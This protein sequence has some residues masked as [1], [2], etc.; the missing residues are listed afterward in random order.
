LTTYDRIELLKQTLASISSQTFSDYEVIIGNDYQKQVLTHEM[1]GTNDSRIHI[2]N[3]PV[4]LG[5]VGNMNAL[6]Q[7]S[8]GQ[9]YTWMGDDDIYTPDFLQKVFDVIRNYS[10]PTAVFTNFKQFRGLDYPELPKVTG[11]EARIYSG[12][13]F[14]HEYLDGKIKTLSAYGIIS[15]RALIEQGGMCNVCDDPSIGI[16]GEYLFMVRCGML[17]TISYLNAPLIYFR[18]HASSRAKMNIDIQLH[19]ATGIKLITE[20]LN[21]IKQAPF[22]RGFIHDLS[23]LLELPLYIWVY[24]LKERDS[25]RLNE[26]DVLNHLLAMKQQFESLKGSGLYFKAIYSLVRVAAKLY[27]HITGPHYTLVK[28]SI[29]AR[30]LHKIHPYIQKNQPAYYKGFW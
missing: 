27:W 19:Y 9:Y 17:E 4:N 29:L 30:M 25:A 2:V 1:I 12:A 8:R 28:P 11:G 21:V 7:L 18:S 20:S 10:Y 16:Y 5:E 14:L 3:H 26:R 15:R 22:Q 24:K 13:H 23:A 6:L